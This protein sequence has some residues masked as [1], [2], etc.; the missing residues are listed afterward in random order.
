VEYGPAPRR[1]SINHY[2]FYHKTLSIEIIHILFKHPNDLINGFASN[3]ILN[4]YKIERG[5]I[6]CINRLYVLLLFN[7]ILFKN[8]QI[9]CVINLIV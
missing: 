6:H 4:I 8:D 5:K 1:S 3:D 9:F 2:S 7:S